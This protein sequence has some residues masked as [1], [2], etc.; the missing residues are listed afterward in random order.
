M[1]SCYT[2]V[3]TKGGKEREDRVMRGITK[4]RGILFWLL[5]VFTAVLFNA[6]GGGG[7]GDGSGSGS[8][9]ALAL[10]S[11][12]GNGVSFTLN[13]GS[14][15]ISDL[16]V[17]YGGHAIGTICSY[18]YTITQKFGTNIPVANNSFV[19]ESNGL[20]IEG[21]FVSATSAEVEVTWSHYNGQCD[22]TEAGNDVLYADHGDVPT[23]PQAGD[24]S[25]I[26]G[27]GE[28]ELLVSPDST[29]I[30]SIVLTYIDFTCGNVTSNGSITITSSW[31]ISNGQFSADLN[32]DITQDRTMKITGTF[33][34]SGTYVSG[35]YEADYSGTICD[36]TWDASPE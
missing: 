18:D 20:K 25:G 24:W 28:I 9:S 30:E 12:S 10:G 31:P 1:P 32:L 35:T 3:F 29:A 6:C 22:A 2:L 21:L 36:G 5:I 16:S 33:D 15:W 11:W 23:L 7:G 14:Y 26:S 27:F 19:H 8:G 4:I 34:D 13:E 17:T